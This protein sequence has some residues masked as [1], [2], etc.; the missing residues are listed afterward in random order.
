MGLEMIWLALGAILIIGI[1]MATNNLRRALVL[2]IKAA[3]GGAAI[4]G[5]NFLLSY[6]GLNFAVPGINPLTV[7]VV[8]FL[9]V[10]GI[11]TIY[12]LNYFL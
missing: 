6:F 2:M 4:W 10:P 9:G 5:I 8:A 1:L 3:V 11:V 12:G 7:S